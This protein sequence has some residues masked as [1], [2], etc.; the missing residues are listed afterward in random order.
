MW[1]ITSGA[2]VH[3]LEFPTAPSSLEVSCDGKLLLIT[4]GH[5]VSIWNLEL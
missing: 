2:D 4:Y 3:K 1:D 5:T